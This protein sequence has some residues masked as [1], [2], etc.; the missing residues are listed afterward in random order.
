MAADTSAPTAE[1]SGWVGTEFSRVFAGH[2]AH[3]KIGVSVVAFGHN[4]DYDLTAT[5]VSPQIEVKRPLNPNFVAYVGD[6]LSPVAL[7]PI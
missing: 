5:C 1:Y 3:D 4:Y 2:G 6:P 7:S